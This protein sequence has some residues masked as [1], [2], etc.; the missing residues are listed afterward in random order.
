M[1]TISD[2]NKRFGKLNVLQSVNVNFQGG[3]SYAMIG[4]N[5]SGKTT[6]I[7]CILGMVL[8]DS[9]TISVLGQSIAHDWS[10]RNHI[11]YMPQIG[12][13]P[14]ANEDRPNL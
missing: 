4:P 11:G 14:R 1:I 8:P 3:R 2:L 5:G 9:G 7:K 6:L 12:R 13:Y 10:Y